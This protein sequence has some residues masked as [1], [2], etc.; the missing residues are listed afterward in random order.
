MLQTS[1]EGT[2]ENRS[3]GYTWELIWLATEVSKFIL[4]KDVKGRS[5]RYITRIEYMA[6]IWDDAGKRATKI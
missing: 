6:Q 5:A 2:I 1:W 4:D 3:F